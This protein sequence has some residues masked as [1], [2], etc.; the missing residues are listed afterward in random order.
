M[1]V[2]NTK[3]HIPNFLFVVFWFLF[4]SR[5]P[6][7]HVDLYKIVWLLGKLEVLSQPCGG[8]SH[9]RG[10]HCIPFQNKNRVCARWVLQG[11]LLL[12]W[13]VKHNLSGVLWL[14]TSQLGHDSL[15]TSQCPATSYSCSRPPWSHNIIIDLLTWKFCTSIYVLRLRFLYHRRFFYRQHLVFSMV[16]NPDPLFRLWRPKT[17]PPHSKMRKNA[18]PQSTH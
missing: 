11:G 15:T 2:W 13:L 14:L 18:S 7:F 10:R 9:G 16:G 3:I 6:F 12:L 8:R 4:Y 17:S 1:L 5:Y